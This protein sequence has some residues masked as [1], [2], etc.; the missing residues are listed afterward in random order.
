VNKIILGKHNAILWDCNDDPDQS[1]ADDLIDI[2][3]PHF[4]R[5]YITWDLSEGASLTYDDLVLTH[6]W[7]VVKGLQK[8][9]IWALKTFLVAP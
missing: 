8:R 2:P 7:T 6:S 1:A 9:Q 4:G 3:I 5:V